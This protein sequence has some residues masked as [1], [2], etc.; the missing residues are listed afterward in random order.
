MM[1]A[2]VL[3][4]LLAAT[5]SL[6]GYAAEPNGPEN[7]ID[8]TEAVRIGVQ[9]LLAEKAGDTSM[10]K[11]QKD[12]LIEYYLVPDQPLLWVND[13]GLTDRAKSVIAE[14]GKADDY[15]LTASDY[16][17]PDASTL[18]C[19]RSQGQGLAR[20]CRGEGELRRARLCQ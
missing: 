5:A 14:I 2:F 1:R 11:A 15:G 9:G 7:L 20:R 13:N 17:L 12:A 3:G 8:Q 19:L 6:P 16:K 4:L 10:R 18:Q